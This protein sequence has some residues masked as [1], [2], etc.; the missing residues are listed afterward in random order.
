MLSHIIRRCCREFFKRAIEQIAED[1]HLLRRKPWHMYT[2]FPIG[3]GL[4]SYPDS[5]CYLPL[6]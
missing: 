3:N 6:S 4:I 1:K 5:L 2:L